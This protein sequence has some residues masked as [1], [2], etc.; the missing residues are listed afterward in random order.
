MDFSEVVQKSDI[1]LKKKVCTITLQMF[2]II[3]SRELDF[4]FFKELDFS[5]IKH[6]VGESYTGDHFC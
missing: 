4:F 6:I 5:D 2:F 3:L 1:L